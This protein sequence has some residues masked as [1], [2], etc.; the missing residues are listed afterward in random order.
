MK[1]G[2]P[3]RYRSIDSVVLGVESDH[4]GHLILTDES[5]DFFKHDEL[6]ANREAML[7]EMEIEGDRGWGWD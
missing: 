1:R 7:Q 6:M 4:P 3:E 2:D 5:R